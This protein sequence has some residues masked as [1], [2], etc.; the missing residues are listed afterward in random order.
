MRA[1]LT[2][3][4]R[5]FLE[6]NQAAAWLELPSA[7]IAAR[8][9]AR[10]PR[11]AR[12]AAGLTGPAAPGGELLEQLLLTRRKRQLSSLPPAIL[13][14]ALEEL[15]RLFESPA[16]ALGA[17]RIAPIP[18][19]HAARD[20]LDEWLSEHGVEDVATNTLYELASLLRGQRFSL[21]YLLYSS[22]DLRSL[23]TKGL[24]RELAAHIPARE[25]KALDDTL[26]GYLES[27]ARARAASRLVLKAQPAVVDYPPPDEATLAAIF[28]RL[29]ALRKAL[30][31]AGDEG[32]PS[33]LFPVDAWI[34]GGPPK[35]T[36]HT[37]RAT[38]EV[39][40][41]GWRAQPL[42]LQVE[43]GDQEQRGQPLALLDAML[44][45]VREPTVEEREQLLDLVGRAAWERVL[46]ALERAAPKAEKQVTTAA[47]HISWRLDAE[48][49]SLELA[50]YLHKRTKT[51][52]LTAGTRL[53]LKKVLEDDTL[54]ALPQDRAVA[55]A[56]AR[57]RYG[58]TP[59]CLE[60][61]EGHPHVYRDGELEHPVRI[62]RA[63][64]ELLIEE[65]GDGFVVGVGVGGARVE[66]IHA[67]LAH[68]QRTPFLVPRYEESRL[69]V[70]RVDKGLAPILEVLSRS[71]AVVPPEGR[72]A[73]LRVLA[74]YEATVGVRLPGSLQ[75]EVVDASADPVARLMPLAGGAL[76]L[77]L[78]VRPIEGGPFFPP[79][80]GAELVSGLVGQHRLTAR[81][82]LAAEAARAT[83]LVEELGLSDEPR[84]GPWAFFLGDPQLALDVV[85]ALS[86]GELGRD[87]VVLEWPAGK[88]IRVTRAARV[89][90]LR[91][92]VKEKRDWLNLEGGV[93]VDGERVALALLLDSARRAERYVRL[94]D[95]RFLALSKEL[96]ERLA[97]LAEAS[98]EVRGR[99]E[100]GVGATAALAE[101]RSG[102]A[103][104]EGTEEFEELLERLRTASELRPTLPRGLTA[105]LRPYQKE[106]FAWLKRL[107]TWGV[108]A[109]LADDM[110]LGKTL[111]TLALLVDRQALGP[112]LVVAPTSVC[113]G[114]LREAERFAPSLRVRMLAGADRK[115]LLRG[116]GPRDVF[117]VSWAVLVR[118][119]EALKA[120]RFATLVMDEAQAIKNAST[121]RSKAA[122][123]LDVQWRLALTGTPVENH[124]GELWAIFRATSPGLLG[125]WDQFRA[126][127]AGPIEREQDKGRSKALARLIR[128]FLLRR[129]KAEVAQDLPERS[130]I[131]CEVE[132]SDDEQRAYEDVRL[133]LAAELALV[134]KGA[135]KDRRFQILRAL[136]RLR[137]RACHPRLDG[138]EGAVSSSKLKAT[139][140]IAADLQEGGHRA[141][142]FSQFTS[143][144]AL[145]RAALLEAGHSLLYLDGS[146]PQAE[147]AALVDRFQAGEADF[148]LI[149]LKA[150]GFGLNLTAADYVLLLDPW[151]NPAVEDQ[152][153]DR[154]HRIG[155][156]RPVT[157]YKLV[158]RGTV[159][160]KI[161]AMQADKR[162]LVAGVLDGAEEAG[163]LSSEELVALIA[164]SRSR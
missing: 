95:D 52:A 46:A 125:S 154:A 27:A 114:W 55:A 36:A 78:G 65:G 18:R 54:P 51:G 72:A 9:R 48:R 5:V 115:G 90:E 144:L 93:E 79:G 139:L 141:L 62:E 145:V 76:R 103:A 86:P 12:A 118:D 108:G 143:H 126:R 53:S 14:L 88:P 34:Q 149:S 106:G 83:A 132:L 94:S 38:A 68:E 117:V 35:L 74:P 142:V 7:V 137:L 66:P 1:A 28:E 57:E 91:V 33:Y 45:L 98:F 24:P 97:P 124:L 82:E 87:D 123:E 85:A 15:L 31:P 129:T 56:L 155:Q 156:T 148:F 135:R 130:E 67:L 100:A 131:V 122:R 157:I 37:R 134:K 107:S 60:E 25:L 47:A 4:A 21:P 159:E 89:D 73:L 64:V 40:L 50:P 69:F 10:S 71:A 99:V 20:G 150:G 110:G 140:R 101:L 113:F 162:R 59:P 41:A 75:G 136:T 84:E 153:A 30:A 119:L 81:R 112:Q 151:W 77:T 104:L 8:M 13:D 61:L 19:G 96:R 70:A 43:G 161:V 102:G 120:L 158:S 23:L 58:A 29:V 11:A 42:S 128:P 6:D 152:A 26:C 105:E 17:P 2:K 160:E 111:Q 109:V 32:P 163:A 22:R 138:E 147:R 92:G 116:A 49:H 16:P 80:E 39:M 146:T 63:R 133:A 121:R 127:F 3:R 164:E 44:E